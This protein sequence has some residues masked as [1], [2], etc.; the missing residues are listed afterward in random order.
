MKPIIDDIPPFDAEKGT[1]I[2]F[3]A[4]KTIYGHKIIIK[5]NYDTEIIYEG[6]FY[7]SPLCKFEIPP[8]SNGTLI[9]G[10]TYV[11]YLIIYEDSDYSYTSDPKM[12]SCFSTPS[13][14][15]RLDGNTIYSS[16]FNIGINY[17]QTQNED[18][19]EFYITIKDISG[20]TVFKS[21]IAYDINKEFE[22]SNLYN[23]SEYIVTA[24][25]KTIS[26]MPIQSEEVSIKTSY[27]KN[28]STVLLN[29]ENDYKN[30]CV[31]LTSKLNNIAYKLKN[32]PIYLAPNGIDLSN[33]RLSYYD[34][35]NID[36]DFS[37]Y[38]KYNPT[39][40]KNTI[41]SCNN[42]EIKLNFK[43]KEQYSLP[44]IAQNFS[45][46]G[47]SSYVTNDYNSITMSVQAKYGGIFINLP[48]NISGA[49]NFEKVKV[50]YKNGYGNFGYACRYSDSTSDEDITWGG[51]LSGSSTFEKTFSAGK[52]PTRIKFFNN[53]EGLSPE[54]PASV[55]ITSI[56]FTGSSLGFFDPYFELFTKN[57]MIIIDK[58][59]NGKSFVNI[60]ADK[61]DFSH[62]SYDI[63]LSRTDN[64]INIRIKDGEK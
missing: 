32:P 4:D 24:Y 48:E 34:G 33:N 21:D 31:K 36:G 47:S 58:D 17:S 28:T 13:F 10:K 20:N 50:T 22:V 44:I 64:Q 8:F 41:L 1:T 3:T 62:Y 59:K 16:V 26:G 57:K 7:N 49:Y 15:I 25:G 51:L 18:L 56:E 35:F 2:T 52:K 46:D 23:N 39:A 42:D 53:T 37:M 55:T 29:A 40:P 45:I 12:I 60:N 14:S 19:N 54:S 9:N 61:Y 30:A 43:T 63:M 5:D 6:D 38:I 27:Y 11:L